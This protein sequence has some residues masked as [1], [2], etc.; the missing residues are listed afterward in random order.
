MKLNF[1]FPS[2][3]A[4][5]S[6]LLLSYN[7]SHGCPEHQQRE[8]T[9]ISRR[10]SAAPRPFR[11]ERLGRRGALGGL[12]IDLTVLFQTRATADLQVPHSRFI[13]CNIFF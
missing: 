7:Q 11:S 6:H 9:V 12:L 4:P 10:F 3:S 8:L 13:M 5:H 2:N 1:R